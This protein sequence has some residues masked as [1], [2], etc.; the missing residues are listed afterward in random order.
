FN[1]SPASHSIKQE[2]EIQPINEEPVPAAVNNKITPVLASETVVSEPTNA[3]QGADTDAF[4]PSVYSEAHSRLDSELSDEF[5]ENMEVGEQVQN[6]VIAEN[7][8]NGRDNN[9]T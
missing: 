7:K 1:D 9:N 3:E 4:A 2:S 5:Q 6:A 8:S